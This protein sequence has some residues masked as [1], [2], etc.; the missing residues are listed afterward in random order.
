MKEWRVLSH[1]VNHGTHHRALI[2]T[3]VC[4]RI[5]KQTKET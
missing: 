4:L 5:M 2:D 3:D 1:G